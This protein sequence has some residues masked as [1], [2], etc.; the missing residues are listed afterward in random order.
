MEFSYIIGASAGS[1]IKYMRVE[2]S[3]GTIH[4]HPKTKSEYKKLIK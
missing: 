1:G 4:G 2:M 3:G